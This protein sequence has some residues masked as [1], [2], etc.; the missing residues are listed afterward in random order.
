MRTR[1][2]EIKNFNRIWEVV[3]PHKSIWISIKVKDLAEELAQSGQSPQHPV[4]VV[5]IYTAMPDWYKNHWMDD[6]R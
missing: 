5:K 2:I 4:L 6:E 1:K 3:K